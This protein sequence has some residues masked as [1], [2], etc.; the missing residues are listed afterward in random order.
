M[1]KTTWTPPRAVYLAVVSVKAVRTRHARIKGI[2]CGLQDPLAGPADC[3]NYRRQV[4]TSLSAELMISKVS[5][6]HQ[7]THHTIRS[8]SC[9]RL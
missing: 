3:L 7:A 8:K 1:Q 9:H 4:N 2:L 5:A 6:I